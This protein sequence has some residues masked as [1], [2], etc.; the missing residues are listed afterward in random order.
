MPAAYLLSILGIAIVFIIIACSVWKWH[1]LIVL[2]IA[3]LATGLLTGIPAKKT[4]DTMLSGAGLVFAGIGFIIVLGSFLGEVLERT[5]AAGQLANQLV[6]RAPGKRMPL[7][8]HAMGL[9]VGIPV[10]CDAGFILLSRLIQS[11]AQVQGSSLPALQLSLGTGLYGTHILIPPTP[12]PMAAAGNLGLGNQLGWVILWGLVLLLPISLITTWL[13]RKMDGANLLA[14]TNTTLTGTAT[15]AIQEN[16]SALWKAFIPLVLPLL[17]IAAGSIL[18]L[19]IANKSAINFL[20]LLGHPVIALGSSALVAL[21]LLARPDKK[22]WGNW[23][24]QALLQSG[25]IILITT[26]GGAFGAVLKATPIQEV[27]GNFLQSASIPD[28]AVYPFAFILAAIL[29]TA[30]GSSTAA[31]IISSALLFPIMGSFALNTAQQALVV[32]AI[33]AGAMTVSHANDSYFWVIHQYGQIPVNQLYRTYT[34]L[35]AA[36]GF[37]TLLG[38]LL[39]YFLTG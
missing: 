31:L 2:L 14:Q 13:I 8:T 22:Q 30:Q 4:V 12:G 28:W 10:F 3:A 36:M 24:G 39:L 23:F 5:G 34:L 16:N 35:T 29:K 19:F 20:E 38:V 26:A 15:T 11:M 1:P 33:G 27:L 17:L 9:L 37:T 21:L 7:Y 6:R 18:P 25:P 32:L